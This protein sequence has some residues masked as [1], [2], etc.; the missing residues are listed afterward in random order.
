VYVGITG[1]SG[2]IGKRLSARLTAAGHTVHPLQRGFAASDLDGCEAVVNLAGEPVVQRWNAD[3]KRRIRESRVN[4][5]RTLVAA[6]GSERR[7]RILVNGSAV[8]YYGDRGDEV[9]TE[10]SSP[11]PGFLG[12]VCIE[13]EREA[14]AARERGIRVALIRTGLVLGPGGGALQQMLTPFRLGVGGRL[15]SGRQWMPWVHL[16]DLCALFE[17]ALALPVE[18]PFNGASPNPVTNADFTQALARTLHR[19]A[20]L[21]VP[22]LAIDLLYGEMSQIVFASQRA[23]PKAAEAA[24]FRFHYSDL[25]QALKAVLT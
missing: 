7:P 20:I 25:T 19:P 9:L 12:D 8:G 10:S 5:T 21:P 18:G 22:R 4:G 11:G 17:F 15:G 23:L 24:N 16:D 6:L 3:V 2:F 1:A 14:L 13:W